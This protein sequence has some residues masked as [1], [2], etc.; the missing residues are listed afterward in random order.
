MN[1]NK[2][3]KKYIINIIFAKTPLPIDYLYTFSLT[4]RLR[5]LE[6]HN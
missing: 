1:I 2:K 3:D 4:S 5:I 6:K